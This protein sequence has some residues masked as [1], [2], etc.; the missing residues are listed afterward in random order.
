MMHYRQVNEDYNFLNV[1]TRLSAYGYIYY[2]SL[3]AGESYAILFFLTSLAIFGIGSAV[4]MMATHVCAILFA[5]NHLY[6]TVHLRAEKCIPVSTTSKKR[7]SCIQR[8]CS[9]TRRSFSSC[10]RSALRTPWTKCRMCCLRRPPASSETTLES[11]SSE[12]SAQRNVVGN[13]STIVKLP[14]PLEDNYVLNLSKNFP[15]PGVSIVKPLAGVDS[16]LEVNLGSYFRLDYPNYEILFCAAD[17]SDPSCRLVRQ[18]QAMYPHV[19]SRMVIA[20]KVVGVNPKINNLQAGYEN[21]RFDLLLISDSGVWMRPDTL[22]DMVAALFAEEKIGMVHQVP[23][24]TPNIY[25]QANT[26]F[27]PRWTQSKSIYSNGTSSPSRSRDAPLWNNVCER[28]SFAWIVQL[29]FFGCWHAKVY[30]SAAFF[31]INCTTGMSCLIRK[32]ILSPLGGFKP[33]GRYLAEDFFLAKYFLDQGWQIRVSHQPAWQNSPSLSVGQFRTRI[34]RWSQL[35]LS[36]VLVAYMLEPLSRCLPNATLGAFSF[37]YFFPNLIDPGV[38]FLCHVLLWFLLDY[39]LLI[40]VY[41]PCVPL[42]ITKL[43]YLIAWVFSEITAVPYHYGAVF[44]K[45]LNWRNKRYRVHWGGVSEQIIHTFPSEKSHP[46]PSYLGTTIEQL[47]TE[48]K[49]TSKPDLSHTL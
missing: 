38:Y 37:S 45:E 1:T 26:D 48:S 39:I 44:K 8:F 7:S 14:I 11:S 25:T 33:F 6:K 47:N 10:L 4:V 42:C 40:H 9:E 36:M 21:S 17:E 19:P 49:E 43:E 27:S 28:P 2:A 15:Y 30:L 46:P 31:G 32:P 12:Y 20:N 23:F 24:M 35:R 3:Y 5:H 13:T 22:T 41:P 29:V 18:L 16:N 34:G